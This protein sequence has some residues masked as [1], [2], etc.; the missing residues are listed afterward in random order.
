MTAD[1]VGEAG[2]RTA[3]TFLRNLWYLG[4]V[5]ATLRPSTMRRQ[6]FLGEPVLLG[7]MNDGLAFALRDI[8]PHRAAPLSAGKIMAENTVQCPYHGWRFRSDGVCSLIPSTVGGQDT[9]DSS[10]IRV[11]SY[12][13]REQDGLIWI[14]L[15]AVE[16]EAP[17]SEPP[18]VPIPQA[19]PRWIES[20]LF[21]CG[22]DEAV[23]GL[24]DPAHAPYVHGRWWWRVT[25]REKVKHYAPVPNGFVMKRHAP[26]KTAYR[27]LGGANVSTEIT[28][29]L[30]STR[31][32]NIQGTIFG[33]RI[34][35]SGLTVCTPL[36][37][38]STQVTQI[39]YWPAW[40]A[41]LKPFFMILGPT[42]L[43]DDRGIVELQKQGLKFDPP[44]M[45][46]QDSDVP[47]MWY[48]RLKKAWAESVATGNPFAN[49]VR[50]RTLRWRS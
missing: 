21:P 36:D 47:A 35:V 2:A 26:T 17:K 11:R 18:R 25:P 7:R 3:P 6:M 48:Y 38:H 34:D 22:I 4:A 10:G 29:E 16:G 1:A 14:Y 41:F 27:I 33:R 28:F 43:S 20:Q 46:I 12:P 31:F 42:F 15:A 23:I 50:E 39:F 45:L 9:I 37:A 49:P 5:S 30:P 44:L 24:M 13:V 19:K 8:C 40:L 32:E